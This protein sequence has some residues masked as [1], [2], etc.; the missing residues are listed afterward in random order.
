M[1]AKISTLGLLLGL[2]FS[3][4]I[5]QSFST[6]NLPILE[7]QTQGATIQDEPKVTV[8]FSIRDKGLGQLNAM[9]DPPAHYQGFAAF[10]YRGNSTLDADKKSYGFELRDAAGADR[11][12]PLL[13]LP[14]EEDWILHASHFDRSFQRNV[15]TFDLW[16]KMGHYAPRTRY[17]ELVVDGEYRGVYIL[18]EKIK[19]DKNRLDI[20]KLKP[21]DNSGDQLTGGYIIRLDW[22][23]APGWY[24]NFDAFEEE[25]KLYFQYYYPKYSEIT[26]PQETYIAA[27]IDSFETALFAGDYFHPS[28]KRYNDFID[29]ESWADLFIINEISRSVD[30]YKLSSFLYKDKQ[31]KGGKLKAGPIWDFDLAFHNADYCGNTQVSGWT[32]QQTAAGCDDLTL[33][34]RWWERLLADPAFTHVVRCR[35]DAHRTQFLANDSVHVQLDQNAAT[36]S[37][38]QERNFEKWELWGEP[39]FID[40]RPIPNSYAEELDRLKSWFEQRMNWMDLYLPDSCTAPIQ[41]PNPADPLNLV[42]APNPTTGQTQIRW[43]DARLVS[44]EIFDLQGK[45]VYW[46]T[47]AFTDHLDV[48][49]GNRGSG[50]FMVRVTADDF[51]ATSKLLVW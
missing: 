35:W 7:I 1:H 9:T 17:C 30:A 32:Y 43:S 16:R 47:E 6:S 24:S 44:V 8:A 36:L 28:G 50:L 3:T 33:M 10:E 25:E 38:A 15:V 41:K 40:P 34:P 21:E 48:D 27:Y 23:E 11:D 12:F 19:R 45:R 26:P 37:Q 4:G 42:L 46:I 5:A 18:M 2:C 49:L 31:S 13:G 29:L 39:V 51:S 14:P 20:A 22:N